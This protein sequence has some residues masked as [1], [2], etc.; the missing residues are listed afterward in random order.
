MA[1]TV[2]A[3]LGQYEIHSPLG[4]GEMGEVYR[5]RDTRIQRMLSCEGL[6]ET[7]A[8][9]SDRAARCEPSIGNMLTCI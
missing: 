6:P 4:A 5:A 1:L 3:L 7:V 9:D 8:E 2:G